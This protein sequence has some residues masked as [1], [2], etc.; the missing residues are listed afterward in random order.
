MYRS[1]LYRLIGVVVL[2]ITNERWVLFV[3]PSVFDFFFMYHLIT[4]RWLPDLEIGSYKELIIVVLSLSAMKLFQE[5]ILHVSQT[6]PL[7]WVN[8]QVI[9]PSRLLLDSFTFG[10]RGEGMFSTFRSLPVIDQ[11]FALNE[12]IQD[13]MRQAVEIRLEKPIFRDWLSAL[14]TTVVTRP[15]ERTCQ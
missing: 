7:C 2:V 1:L 12:R 15:Y 9:Q 4:M 3:F 11:Y 14:E 13:H 6:R 8:I 10:Y 5:Y